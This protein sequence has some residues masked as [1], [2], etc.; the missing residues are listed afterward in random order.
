MQVSE[1]WAKP[2]SPRR[3]APRTRVSVVSPDAYL[4]VGS[5][6]LALVII[7]NLV[8]IYSFFS[9]DVWRVR[10]VASLFLLNA[11]SNFATLFNFSLIA[12]N[13]A[14]L[15]LISLAAFDERDRWRWHWTVLGLLFLLLAYDEAA[16]FHERLMPIG[17]A[18]VGG[19]GVLF[20]TWVIFGAAFVLV[21]GLAYLRFVLA[22]PRRTSTLFVVAGALYVGGAL[23]VELWGGRFASAHGLDN[24]GFHLIATVEETLEI[25]GQILF[26]HALLG[27]IVAREAGRG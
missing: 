13:A 21:V 4:L 19:E 26:G 23:G 3:A 25:A 8:A 9:T 14:L 15:G 12:V 6:I 7:L 18:L 11:E 17:R 1:R 20:F 2:V 24:V 5:A 22:L 16:S 10:R 27:H